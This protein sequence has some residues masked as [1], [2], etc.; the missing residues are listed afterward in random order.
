METDLTARNIGQD[1]GIGGGGKDLARS[2][3][4]RL[5][6]DQPLR[7]PKAAVRGASTLTPIGANL[8]S[9]A[10]ATG[11]EPDQLRYQRSLQWGL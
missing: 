4:P 7:G 5:A 10:R 9:V 1:P 11:A 3:D 2:G 8:R 6:P